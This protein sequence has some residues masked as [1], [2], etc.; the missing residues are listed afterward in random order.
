MIKRGRLYLYLPYWTALRNS[1][2][3]PVWV[4]RHAERGKGKRMVEYFNCHKPTHQ[5]AFLGQHHWSP[6]SIRAW[7]WTLSSLGMTCWSPHSGSRYCCQMTLWMPACSPPCTQW[8]LQNNTAV[9]YLLFLWELRY[10][11]HRSVKCCLH[12]YLKTAKQHNWSEDCKTM[13]LWE[14]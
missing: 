10:E 14:L 9:K 1:F 12:T 4:V 6:G 3:R 7:C 8:C 13:Q 5:L 2:N 11:R